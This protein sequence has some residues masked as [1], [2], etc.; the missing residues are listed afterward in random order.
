[1]ISYRYHKGGDRVAQIV[2]R[3]IAEE[4]MLGL[5]AI[6]ERHGTSA[7]HEVRRLLTAAV[8]RD[9]ALLAFRATAARSR[10]RLVGEGRS[11]EDST[12]LIRADRDR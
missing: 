7:E 9:R 11:F 3:N 5:K 1:M 12:Q 8:D 6:A 2:V 4:T 10:A